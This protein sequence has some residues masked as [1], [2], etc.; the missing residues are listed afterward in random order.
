MRPFEFWELSDRLLQNEAN[1]AG[2]RNA[3]SRSYY[4]AFLTAL[5]FLDEAGVVIPRT[6]KKGDMHRYV[7]DLLNNSGD[8]DIATAGMMLA[9]LRD[10]RN[11]ADY[12]YQDTSLETDAYARSRHSE[13]GTIIAKL[14]ACRQTKGISGGRFD[15]VAA[16]LYQR[17]AFL[18]SGPPS[19]LSPPSS[20]S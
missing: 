19:S 7:P 4:S 3:I 11:R 15:A 8:Q 13:A 14:N 17:A 16:A 18:F 2:F 9:N 6:V 20:G 5:V 10:E 1:P 12:E